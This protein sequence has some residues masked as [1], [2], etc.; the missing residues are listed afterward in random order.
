MKFYIV[1]PEETFREALA[2]YRKGRWHT[3]IEEAMKEAGIDGDDYTI[4]DETGK[5]VY[6]AKGK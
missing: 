4:R 5:V 2:A 3:S 1:W 6:K